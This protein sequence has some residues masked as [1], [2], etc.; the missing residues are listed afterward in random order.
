MKKKKK[1]AEK[2]PKQNQREK[3]QCNASQSEFKVQY[4]GHNVR[5]LLRY[6]CMCLIVWR[7]RVRI[8]HM[9]HIHG[10]HHVTTRHTRAA[11]VLDG[12]CAACAVVKWRNS[13]RFIDIITSTGIKTNRTIHR[14]WPVDRRPRSIC[15]RIYSTIYGVE[16]WTQK[17]QYIHWH[18][19]TAMDKEKKGKTAK[20]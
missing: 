8:L 5:L 13:L 14:Q 9:Q 3:R 4:N 19:R 1:K 17:W 12:V 2:S 18:N 11:F 20:R 15:I 7:M 6:T 10:R 16:C